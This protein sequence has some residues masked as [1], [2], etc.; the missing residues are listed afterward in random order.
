MTEYTA[1]RSDGST[2]GV[3]MELDK[4]HAAIWVKF[5]SQWEPTIFDTAY[6]RHDPLWAAKLAYAYR[7]GHTDLP[8]VDTVQAAP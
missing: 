8:E 5:G 1:T 7:R 6:A 2:F 4:P 3:R